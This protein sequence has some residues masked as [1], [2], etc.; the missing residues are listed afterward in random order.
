MAQTLSVWLA[1]AWLI[2]AA[3]LVVFID[4][5][6]VIVTHGTVAR[7]R[8]DPKREL[9][10]SGLIF[11]SVAAMLNVIIL[12]GMNV[13]QFFELVTDGAEGLT[14]LFSVVII[15]LVTGRAMTRMSSNKYGSSDSAT[16]APKDGGGA[17]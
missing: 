12:G 15:P 4:Y 1:H 8:A 14:L 7:W 5:F 3:M 13:G 11:L 2:L 16:V 9:E 17:G 10:T 6:A